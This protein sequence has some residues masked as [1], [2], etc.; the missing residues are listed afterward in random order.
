MPTD[1]A[2]S[3]NYDARR[4]LDRR[5]LRLGVGV[6][7]IFL[8]AMAFQ[9]T[10][11]YLAPI[12]FPSLLQASRPLRAAEAVKLLVAVLVVMLG[13]YALAAMSRQIPQLFVLLLIPILFVTFRSLF[14]GGPVLIILMVLIGLVLPPLT[15]KV[16][17]DATWDVSASFV[18]NLGLCVIVSY[19]L[20]RLFPCL[21]G[22]PPPNPRPVF[23]PAEA[24]WRAAMLAVI[25][26]GYMLVYLALDWHNVHTPLYI[27]VFA[28]TLGFSRTAGLAKGILIANIVGGMVAV[29]MFELTAM[30]PIFL[31][32][33]ALTLPVMIVFAR[34]VVSE[35]P[36]APLASF[37][38]SVVL[39]IFG[40]SIG[41]Y[42]SDTGFE[43]LGYRLFELGI[44][45]IYAVA[46]T[47]VLEIFRPALKL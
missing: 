23:P 31:F 2:E 36:W 44:A 10:L 25:V 8:L 15:A 6:T 19:L 35:A 9:W 5:A 47:F 16:S 7:A 27:V 14:R 24:D 4:V 1:A 30:A 22:E 41:P 17:L 13:T 42:N 26:G 20:F 33:A 43:N 45:A 46:A 11:A 32:L 40:S 38:M 39:L 29:V 37:A 28:S 34:A 12:F 21:P 3:A 18:I